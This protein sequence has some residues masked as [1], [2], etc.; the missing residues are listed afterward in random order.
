M[1]LHAGII[2]NEIETK[3]ITFDGETHE[4]MSHKFSGVVP[5]HCDNVD[6]MF[7]NIKSLI[8]DQL[9]CLCIC[10][11][12]SYDNEIRETFIERGKGFGFD[13][14]EITDSFSAS[15]VA[16]ISASDAVFKNKLQNGDFVWVFSDQFCRIWRKDEDKI[17]FVM[18]FEYL[19]TV[20]SLKNIRNLAGFSPDMILYENCHE[21]S[22]GILEKMFRQNVR[23][24]SFANIENGV[25]IKA[26]IMAGD[27]EV[28]CYNIESLLEQDIEIRIGNNT[29][30][31]AK[32][33]TPLP[34]Y[35]E[36]I[37]ENDVYANV[38]QVR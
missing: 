2:C 14:V 30:L 7:K 33:G 20:E 24:F 11:E 16:L 29:V 22:H 21:I 17:R 6:G 32:T 38:A 37:V 36:T 27:N 3:F 8:N 23:V 4:Q 19:D 9:G 10:L 12:N 26:R 1:V 35:I 25:L 15:F 34:Y 31:S 18:E 28:M 5:N 13:K